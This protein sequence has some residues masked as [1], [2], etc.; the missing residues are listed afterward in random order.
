MPVKCRI[1]YVAE[2]TIIYNLPC[3]YFVKDTIRYEFC[4]KSFLPISQNT[5]QGEF[6]EKNMEVNG[7]SVGLLLQLG[8]FCAIFASD[9]HDDYIQKIDKRNFSKYCDFLK[10]PHHGSKTSTKIL[11]YFEP[12]IQRGYKIKTSSVTKKTIKLP[13]DEAI[14]KYASVSDNIIYTNE[15]DNGFNYGIGVV[16]ADVTDINIKYD[17]GFEGNANFKI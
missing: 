10:I 6:N 8:E 15:N 16:Y 7:F 13:S 11:D 4:I 14:N 2:N 17:Y 3:K 12:A 5:F 1:Q 9:C